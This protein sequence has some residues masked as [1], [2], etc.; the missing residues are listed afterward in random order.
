MCSINHEWKAVYVHIPKNGGLYVQTVLEKFYGFKTYY[1]TREDHVE[2]NE[3]ACLQPKQTDNKGFIFLRKKGILRYYMT[4]PEF[5]EMS[6]MDEEKWQ[7][8]RKF[9]VLRNPYDKLVSAWRY[10]TRPS[11]ED[12]PP[13][14]FRE[15]LE[16][17]LSCSDYDYT[18]AF[19]TQKDHLLGLPMDFYCRFEN[20]NHDLVEVLLQLGCKAISHAKFIL[21][22]VKINAGSSSA[23]YASIYTQETLD[24]ANQLLKEDFEVPEYAFKKQCTMDELSVYAKATELTDVQFIE[25]NRRLMKDLQA[26]YLLHEAVKPKEF[27]LSVPPQVKTMQLPSGRTVQ[28]TTRQT[29]ATETASVPPASQ[30][31]NFED[32]SKIHRDNIMR[33][34]EGLSRQTHRNNV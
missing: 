19:I 9:T 18:H 26:R 14:K 17:E 20:L 6:G 30:P 13:T 1:F 21:D 32:M 16:S 5:S 11:E 12:D 8:Y 33:L 15:F 31:P 3:H 23:S 34:F 27:D 2:F 28:L 4:S 10:L 24:L 22:G 25:Q 29:V 7:T